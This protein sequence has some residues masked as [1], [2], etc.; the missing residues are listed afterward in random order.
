MIKSLI[1]GLYYLLVLLKYLLKD[2]KERSYYQYF[3]KKPRVINLNAN[4]VCNSQCVMCNIWQQQPSYEMSPKE[5]SMV[6]NSKLYKKVEHVGITGGEPTLR[7]DLPEIFEVACNSLPNLKALSII[8]NS[9]ETE[10]VINKIASIKRICTKYNIQLSVMVSLDGYGPMHDEVRRITGNFNAALRVIDFLKLEDIPFS[11]GA[12]ISKVNVWEIDDLLQFAVKNEI[13]ARFRI[14]EFISR[15]YNDDITNRIRNFNDEEVFHLSGF[16]KKLEYRYEKSLLF[17]NTYLNIISMLNG[18]KRNIACPYKSEGVV[19]NARGEI[20]YCAPKSQIIGTALEKDSLKVYNRNLIERRRILKENCNNCI[21]DYHDRLIF[22]AKLRELS[23]EFYKRLFTI[24][25]IEKSAYFKIISRCYIRNAKTKQV[26][27]TGWY[28]TETVGDKAILGSIF[29]YYSQKYE[30]VNFVVSSLYPFV[31]KKTLREINVQSAIIDVYSY[32]FIKSIYL[33][34]VIVMGGGPLMDIG[35]MAIPLWAFT[36]AKQKG[37]QTHIFGCGLGPLK[38]LDTIK[39]IFKYSDQIWLR[40]QASVQLAK[41]AVSDSDCIILYGDPAKNYVLKRSKELIQARREKPY[42]AL[43]LRE[44]PYDYSNGLGRDEFEKTKKDFDSNLAYFIQEISK[45]YSISPFAYPMHTF[46]VGQDDRDYFRKIQ[47][48]FLQED[49]FNFHK[50][51]SSVDETIQVMKGAKINIT[52]RFHSV[53]FA[54]TLNTSFYPIDYTNGGKIKA[55]LEDEGYEHELQSV[56]TFS[57]LSK[58]EITK[59]VSNLHMTT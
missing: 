59:I 43:F 28:G 55:Y 53:L 27:I 25:S 10:N 17:K 41:K 9:I 45:Q 21:H 26:L 24:K 12:T 7:E 18:G 49:D 34:D 11:I 58:N 5:F 47:R 1:Y 50:F 57:K 39:S 46:C 54:H 19:L 29:D 56:L 32:N 44:W 52:M 20:A 48:E 40:D 4:D 15:L 13:N 14:A 37:I 8:T 23:G 42:F 22:R 3:S 16:F 6:F 33:S 2:L 35:E 51:N 36:L 30:E 31:T 38:N